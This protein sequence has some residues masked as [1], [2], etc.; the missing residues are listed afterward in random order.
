MLL[1]NRQI[2]TFTHWLPSSCF[3]FLHSLLFNVV[4]VFYGASI[5]FR[6]SA[7]C[8][9][10]F[11]EYAR[12][13]CTTQLLARTISF[14][15]SVFLLLFILFLFIYYYSLFLPFLAQRII[16]IN[17]HTT[18]SL[19]VAIFG[20]LVLVALAHRA[21]TERRNKK[22]KQIRFWLVLNAVW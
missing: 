6:I 11:N 15:H 13:S 9:R 16:I 18:M 10:Q 8:V 19:F 3:F 14:F 22:K 12:F 21:R 20:V 4:K 5:W 2:P 1:A 17:A 7:E